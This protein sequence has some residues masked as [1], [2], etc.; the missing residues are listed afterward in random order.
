MED[1]RQ[2]ISV[3]VRSGHASSVDESQKADGA[4]K[5]PAA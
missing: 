5:L 2:M 3:E 1:S 4:C